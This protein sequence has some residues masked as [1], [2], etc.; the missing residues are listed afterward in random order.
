MSGISPHHWSVVQLSRRVLVVP[1]A[2]CVQ[3]S[4]LKRC[5]RIVGWYEANANRIE[6]RCEQVLQ[7]VLKN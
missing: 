3:R 4:E 1:W 2:L 5:S 6:K 7:P